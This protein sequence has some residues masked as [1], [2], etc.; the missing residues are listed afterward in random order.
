MQKSFVL[1]AMIEIKH[2]E[3]LG[4]AIIKLGGNP[5]FKSSYSNV[6][7]FWLGSYVNYSTTI[8]KILLD[9][10]DTEKIAISVTLKL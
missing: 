8:K 6:G 2:L 3:L 7:R 1:I 5:E 4:E 10:I 9:N